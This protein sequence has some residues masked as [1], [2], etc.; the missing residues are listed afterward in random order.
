M[1]ERPNEEKQVI[2]VGAGP[3]GLTAAYEL[4]KLSLR[5]SCSKSATKLGGLARTENYQGFQFD[6]G[7]HRFFTK[8]REIN[9]MRR[10]FA[11]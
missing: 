9:Q 3:A 10:D 2:I 7:G 11:Q 6:M 1:P 8:V 4:T 5:P